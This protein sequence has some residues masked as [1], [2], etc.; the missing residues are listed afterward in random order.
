MVLLDGVLALPAVVSPIFSVPVKIYLTTL[1]MRCKASAESSLSAPKSKLSLPVW[2]SWDWGQ[3][4]LPINIHADRQE[5]G[6]EVDLLD[7]YMFADREAGTLITLALGL[8]LREYWRAVEVEDDDERAPEFLRN[9]HLDKT[10]VNERVIRAIKEAISRLPSPDAN[11]EPPKEKELGGSA[12]GQKARASQKKGEKVLTSTRAPPPVASTSK[13]F[14]VEKEVVSPNQ[15]IRS[16]RVR[17][18]SKKLLDSN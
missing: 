13:P 10:R 18:P 6:K 9:S 17:K 5:F 1:Y 12:K 15:N 11:K 14:S 4:Y 7:G 3:K 2:A 8:L 16:Q